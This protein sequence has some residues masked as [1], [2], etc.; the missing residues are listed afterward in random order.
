MDSATQE[1]L[2]PGS[3][4]LSDNGVLIS[5]G[6]TTILKYVWAGTGVEVNGD[7]TTCMR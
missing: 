1:W 4:V 7:P 6:I 5:N 3:G 2:S